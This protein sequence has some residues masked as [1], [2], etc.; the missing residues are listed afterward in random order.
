MIG[1]GAIRFRRSGSTSTDDDDD[2]DGHAYSLL[3]I[4]IVR[5]VQEKLKHRIYTLRN[6]HGQAKEMSRLKST[7]PLWS[8]LD[9][10]SKSKCLFDGKDVLTW[11]NSD[12]MKSYFSSVDYIYYI[13]GFSKGGY[14]FDFAGSW[15]SKIDKALSGGNTMN[16]PHY[17]LHVENPHYK[18]EE[19]TQVIVNLIQEEKEH[20]QEC[21]FRYYGIYI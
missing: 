6:P 16:Y 21:I 3:R 1:C 5:G 14:S 11:M 17:L 7:N 4:N 9:E 8:K 15:A 10:E 13:T 19:R 20:K 12:Q 2:Y 18:K